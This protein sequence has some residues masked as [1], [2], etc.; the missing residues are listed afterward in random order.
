M[1]Q[2]YRIITSDLLK[3]I[4]L[5]YSSEIGEFDF[6]VKPPGLTGVEQPIQGNSRKMN[7]K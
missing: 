2:L 4:L 3:M 1:P 5:P 6:F 7:G